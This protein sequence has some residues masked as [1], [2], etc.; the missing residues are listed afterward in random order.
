L[1]QWAIF[2]NTGQ[3]NRDFPARFN[4]KETDAISGNALRNA[5]AAPQCP[6]ITG[7][8]FDSIS[9]SPGRYHMHVECEFDDRLVEDIE[10]NDRI[11]VVSWQR[12]LFYFSSRAILRK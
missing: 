10:V 6:R 12:F 9:A 7:H 2:L 4:L 1:E 8:S 3:P 5:E 11:M